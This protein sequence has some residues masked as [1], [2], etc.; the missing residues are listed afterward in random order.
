MNFGLPAKERAK[1][2]L[3]DIPLGDQETHTVCTLNPSR[4]T[5]SA[6]VCSLKFDAASAFTLA[7]SRPEVPNGSFVVFAF[8]TRQIPCAVIK[9]TK[10]VVSPVYDT[11]RDNDIR[12]PAALLDLRTYEGTP[13]QFQEFRVVLTE[14]QKASVNNRFFNCDDGHARGLRW[15]KGTQNQND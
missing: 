14:E 3:S 8:G 7:L 15:L 10:G 4:K 6:P 2:L 1:R 9:D 11:R 12:I 13:S 5:I